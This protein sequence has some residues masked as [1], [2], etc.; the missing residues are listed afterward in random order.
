MSCFIEEPIMNIIILPCAAWACDSNHVINHQRDH[1]MVLHD[2]TVEGSTACEG[3]V[4]GGTVG[5]SAA[6]SGAVKV[7]SG[8]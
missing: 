3:T 8:G 7:R 1:V 6:Q 5:G 4:E 2:G